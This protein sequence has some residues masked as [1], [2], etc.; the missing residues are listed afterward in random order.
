M[1]QLSNISVL[2]GNFEFLGLKSCDDKCNES[3]VCR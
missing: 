1:A 2:H 3:V